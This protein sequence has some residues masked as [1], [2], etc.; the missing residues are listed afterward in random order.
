MATK[1][2]EGEMNKPQRKRLRQPLNRKLS[3]QRKM[4]FNESNNLSKR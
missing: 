4:K 2:T 3:K 1:I